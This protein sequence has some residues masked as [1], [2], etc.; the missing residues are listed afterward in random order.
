MSGLS[1]CFLAFPQLLV[2]S[3]RLLNQGPLVSVV[4]S[5]RTVRSAFL[6]LINRIVIDSHSMVKG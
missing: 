1:P 2:W 5:F 6:S 3:Y 4:F